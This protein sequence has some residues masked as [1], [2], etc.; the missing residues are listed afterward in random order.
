VET[1]V[2]AEVTTETEVTA[3]AP[4]NDAGEEAPETK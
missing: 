2:E 4:T 1:P 3:E